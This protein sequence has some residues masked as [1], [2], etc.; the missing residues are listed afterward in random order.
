[1]PVKSF[2]F[3][4][5][6]V[7]I[8]EIDNSFRP[9]RPDA[10]GPVVI[11][12]SV[13]GLAMQPVKVESFSDF[14]TMYGDTV[15]GNAGGDIYRDG[16]YQSPMYGT[17]AAKAFL[18]ASVA[19][20]TYVRLLGVE[21][22]NKETG[23]EA[24]WKTT[25]GAVFSGAPGDSRTNGGAYGLWAFP[26]TTLVQAT[27]TVEFTGTPA[28]AGTI[29]IVSS[30]GTSKAYT[31]VTSTSAPASGQFSVDGSGTAIENL[32]ANLKA[33]I[34]NAAGHDGKITVSV[35]GAVATLTQ[36]LAGTEGNQPV[37]KT[38]SNTT[39][40]DFTGGTSDIGSGT[41]SAVWYLDQSS[42]IQ[43]SGNLPSTAN[44][45]DAA[46]DPIIDRAAQGVGIV[47]ES[48]SA[49]N[50]TAFISG[51]KASSG[52]NEKFV[53]N[54]DDTDQRFIRKVFNTNPQLVS[55]GDFYDSTLERNYWLGGTFEQE[56]RD[57]GR[58]S[59]TGSSTSLVTSKMFGVI[60]PIEKGGVGPGDM[61]VSTQEAQ[62]GWFIGQDLGAAGS[63]LPEEALKLFKLKGRGHGEWL[64]KN[65]KISIEKIR[66]SNTQTSDYGSFSV[67][68][69]TL[70]DTDTNPVI[71]ERF[72]NLSL[73]SRSPDYISRRI[74][75]KYLQW[76]E[77]ERRL[78][79][80]GEYLNQS[81][82]VY[83]S[84]INEGNIQ[85]ANSLIPFGYYGPPNFAPVTS[86]SGSAS[87]TDTVISTKY[88]ST[89]NTLQLVHGP[90]VSDTSF[91]C[92][93][94]SYCISSVANSSPSSLRF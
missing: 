92:C 88:I 25:A 77:T 24:G 30:D 21:N 7:F 57:G 75:D 73:D 5:P 32:A 61:Q 55:S 65:V 59:L 43:L 48:D 64:N 40:T 79:E 86:W 26:N 68:L 72:D 67:V 78:R 9:R 28:D 83:V 38:V 53:F 39:T 22:D 16:N 29:T 74:G 52:A 87:D 14:L 31:K 27:A 19:P 49:G 56:L 90:S 70:T 34:E 4:S 13:R 35:A 51:S 63:Y 81:K 71:L 36:A 41:L 15:P 69:R 10:I 85:N 82:F 91:R 50:F 93:T 11:G 84:D 58:N 66:Y 44:Y 60:L 1:M 42:S 94:K 23:G 80:Y 37:V 54:F 47:V 6:G 2:K 33:C 12:R 45:T 89:G 20:V 18:N 46:G 8:N 17:Y 76:S 62:T 3:V